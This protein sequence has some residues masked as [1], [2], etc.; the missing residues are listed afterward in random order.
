M[1]TINS[2]INSS[3]AVISQFIILIFA[4]IT[5]TVFINVLGSEYLGFDTLF[6]NVLSILSIVDLGLGAALTYSLFK[7]IRNGEIEKVAAIIQYFKKM[8]CWLGLLMF[9]LSIIIVPFIGEL[10][11]G[12]ANS[13]PYMQKV[14]LFYAVLTFSSYMFMDV[15]TV[16]Y[17][18][19]QNYKVLMFD[20]LTKIV[21][22]TLQVIILLNHPSYLWYLGIEIIITVFFNIQLMRKAHKDYSI[23]YDHPAKL[24]ED[25][26]NKIFN[27]VKYLSL[28]K[29]ANVGINGTDS[30]I[31][32][33]FIGTAALG[34]YSNY[35]LILVSASSLLWG[36][37]SGVAASLGDLFAEDD[38]TKIN[39]I[40][41]LY[42][43]ISVQ[44]GTFYVAATL[45]L[46]QPF[47]QLWIGEDYVMGFAVVVVVIMNNYY[48]LI[49]APLSNVIATK[50]LFKQ[51]LPIRLIQVVINLVVSIILAINYGLL[52]VFIGT[53]VCNVFGY[54][55]TIYMVV[56]SNLKMKLTDY[57]LKE[58]K[59]LIISFIQVGIIV[60]LND[61]LPFT[62]GIVSFL[63]NIVMVVGAYVLLEL[64]F[65]KKDNQMLILFNILQ[66]Q[67]NRFKGA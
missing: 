45:C 1:R 52:G 7:P 33:K 30:V 51:E 34:V 43:F 36:F 67:L 39:Q 62:E 15:R 17:A 19:Q 41:N 66:S 32:S 38:K 27:D 59:Y 4:F 11:K 8:F 14:F 6:T 60:I 65:Y 18:Y 50:G 28:S 25:D 61:I 3:F 57:I 48:G 20:F 2:L 35:M 46:I 23:L 47:I 58:T 9:A 44:I 40:F 24:N 29:I 21:T 42:S 22:K 63:F 56:K 37:L 54:I 49:T 64:L 31:I 26:R 5:R 16:Y 55:L 53:A 13:I 10:V 12:S